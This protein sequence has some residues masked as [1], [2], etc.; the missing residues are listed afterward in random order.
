MTCQSFL[1]TL[2]KYLVRVTRE[3]V[4]PVNSCKLRLG[5]SLTWAWTCSTSGR[6]YKNLP[7]FNRNF[8]KVRGHLGDLDVDVNALL[9]CLL[10]YDAIQY[11][12]WLPALGRNLLLPCL[13]YNMKMEAV[14]SSETSERTADPEDKGFRL[15]RNVSK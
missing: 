10:P 12:V 1:I 4:D 13:G 9:K 2:M 5:T 14:G 3:F 8:H 6:D 11:G 15:I 7:N